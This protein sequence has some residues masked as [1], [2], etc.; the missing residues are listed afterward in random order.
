MVS[1]LALSSF[2]ADNHKEIP[3]ALPSSKTLLH[4]GST[5]IKL[6]R[7]EY[8]I[9]IKIKIMLAHLFKKKFSCIE[10]KD[11]IYAKNQSICVYGYNKHACD[12]G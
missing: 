7:K 2:S 11:T 4:R 10:G 3:E 6:P 5:K 9:R 8:S 12:D 1:C